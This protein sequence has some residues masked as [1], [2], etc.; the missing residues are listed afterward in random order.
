[1]C[2]FGH[3]KISTVNCPKNG[4]VWFY[5]AVMCTKEADKMVSSADPDQTDSF[6]AI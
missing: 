2:Q 1:M 3:T 4:I 5:K 6:E